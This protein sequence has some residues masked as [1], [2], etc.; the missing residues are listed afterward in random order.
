[1]AISEER[2]EE[3]KKKVGRKKAERTAFITTYK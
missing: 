2:G 3:G 1:L